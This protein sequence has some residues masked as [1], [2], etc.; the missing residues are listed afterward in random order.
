MDTSLINFDKDTLEPLSK[1]V[2]EVMNKLEKATGWIIR[3]KG[4]RKDWEDALDIYKKGIEENPNMLPL[5]KASYIAF[6][7]ETLKKYC[8]LNDIA[9]IA[10]EQMNADSNPEDID[11]DW[12]EYFSEHAKSVYRK[13]AKIMWG[14]ILAEECNESGKIPKS[15]L[16]IITIMNKEEAVTFNELC[17]FIPERIG[18]NGNVWRAN[19]LVVNNDSG[20]IL[21]KHGLNYRTIQD[22]EALGLLHYN[23]V[24][25]RA[26][27]NGDLSNAKIGFKYFDSII[28]IS[29][30]KNEFE[31]GHVMLTQNGKILSEIIERKRINGFENYLKEYYESRGYIV[32][33]PVLN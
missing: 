22:L 2:L 17:G 21:Q 9:T 12:M 4:K 6:A 26:K 30:L 1:I 8:N 28:E 5:L 32:K 15:L 25:I 14:K 27:L 16:H 19:P 13:D 7:R 23:V 11:E 20:D 3:P 33:M 10:I 29:N 18:E 31:E 24:D